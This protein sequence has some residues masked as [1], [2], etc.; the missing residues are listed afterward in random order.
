M[1]EVITRSAKVT[2]TIVPGTT[3]LE[4]YLE[5]GAR[6]VLGHNGTRTVLR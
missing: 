3:V 4:Q 1:Y 6:T 5:N 2:I